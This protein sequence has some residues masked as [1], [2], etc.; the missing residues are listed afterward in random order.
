MRQA[1]SKIYMECI[2]IT[3]LKKKNKSGR[4]TLP[5]FKTI[6]KATIIQ[7]TWHYWRNRRKDQWTRIKKKHISKKPCQLIILKS[8]LNNTE[9]SPW[10]VTI[11][12]VF[13]ESIFLCGII[14]FWLKGF[15]YYFLQRKSVIDELFMSEVCYW[16]TCIAGRFFTI[17]ATR[18]TL[19]STN[20]SIYVL[21]ILPTSI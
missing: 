14:F 8:G 2:T 17:W 5:N 12:G 21:G 9:T 16:W 18:E 4:S 6:Y 3:I 15:L 19:H 11:P 10:V 1:Y 20:Y 13:P 7:I